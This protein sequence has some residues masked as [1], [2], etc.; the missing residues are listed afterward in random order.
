MQKFFRFLRRGFYI[1]KSRILKSSFGSCGQDLYIGPKVAIRGYKKI[2]IGE[3]VR[4]LRG[5]NIVGNGGLT[6][7]D[8]VRFAPESVVLTRN[9]NYESQALPY[10]NTYISKSVV[11][12]NNV[13]IGTRVIILPGVKIEEGAI[14]AAG[15][16]VTKDVPKLAICGGNPGTVLKYRDKSHYEKIKSTGNIHQARSVLDVL[17]ED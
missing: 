13:W 9:H 1:I 7:G 6:I 16:V 4:I 10:D 8:N 15:T 14:I 17:H 5:C 2:T 3:N 12:G 11:I